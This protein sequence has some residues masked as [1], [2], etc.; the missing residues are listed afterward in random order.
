VWTREQAFAGPYEAF[1]PDLSMVLADGGT[2]SILPS[3][4]IVARRS[5]VRGQHRW[6]GVFMACGPGIRRAAEVEE[7]S[8]VDVAP[9]L[10]HRLG[11][12]VPDD[13]AG[14]LPTEVLDADELERHPP[15]RARA[16]AGAAPAF[17]SAPFELEPDEEV[18]VLERLRALGYVE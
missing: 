10:L 9:L 16:A 5:E 18:A 6:Q 1:G 8:I 15:R 17:E 2:M 14:R 4:G 13:M 11:L 7:L 12:P 3:E